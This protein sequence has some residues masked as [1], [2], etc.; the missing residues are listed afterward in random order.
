M[1]HKFGLNP[2]VDILQ[3]A[4][5]ANPLQLYY[6]PRV[7]IFTFKQYLLDINQPDYKYRI[8]DLLNGMFRSCF[9]NFKSEKSLISLT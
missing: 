9:I 6:S 8:T 5:N 7:K 4:T 2:K 1:N 3:Y